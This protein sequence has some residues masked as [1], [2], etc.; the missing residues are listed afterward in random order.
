MS[1]S[2]SCL[3][4]IERAYSYLER[5]GLSELEC[6]RQVQWLA[7]ALA[8]ALAQGPVTVSAQE[9]L[10]KQL[11]ANAAIPE[12]AAGTASL[13]PTLQ[14]GSIGYARFGGA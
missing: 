11:M 2:P 13:A 3:H 10:W 12:R 8:E 1:A 5:A 4:L 6:C 14:R 7:G 9:D